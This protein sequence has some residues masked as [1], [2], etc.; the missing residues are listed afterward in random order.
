MGKVKERSEDEI[1]ELFCAL[2]IPKADLLKQRL[3]NVKSQS[4]Y[5]RARTRS[6]LLIK[7]QESVLEMHGKWADSTS[8]LRQ[9]S[10][11]LFLKA[12][13]N[14]CSGNFKYEV[15][16]IRKVQFRCIS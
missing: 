10:D 8:S 16:F 4:A 14:M 9:Y 15:V 13:S 2:R 11:V 12:P 1:I 7:E 3:G 5:I 6:Q